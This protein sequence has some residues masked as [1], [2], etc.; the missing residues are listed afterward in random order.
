MEV[1]TACNN[2]LHEQKLLLLERDIH[3]NVVQPSWP[4]WHCQ[5]CF[6]CLWSHYLLV[7]I[8]VDVKFS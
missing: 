8:Q 1:Q 6:I 4:H 7:K 3:G 2:N 5:T